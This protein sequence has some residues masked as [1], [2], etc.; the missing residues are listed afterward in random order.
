M[1]SFLALQKRAGSWHRK[2]FP[3][4]RL[5][6]VALKLFEEG[7][8]VASAVLADIGQNSAT[9]DGDVIV[10][11]ADVIICLMVLLDRWFDSSD[12][13]A[14]VDRK[15]DILNDPTSRHRSALHA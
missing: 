14:E 12:V 4:A 15:L 6:L 7:G 1:K 3:N 10:E 5:E 11:A 2:R 9:G 13:L 8:E